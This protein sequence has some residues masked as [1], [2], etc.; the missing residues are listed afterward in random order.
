MANNGY[1]KLWNV[2][3]A[4]RNPNY[5]RP[6][7]AWNS[8][9]TKIKIKIWL[10]TDKARNKS[11]FIRFLSVFIGTNTNDTPGFAGVAHHQAG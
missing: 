5:F 1:H 9:E 3:K 4:G 11:V 8:L 7:L 2:N 6:K 10:S